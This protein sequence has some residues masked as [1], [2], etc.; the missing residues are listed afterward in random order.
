M[1]L[2]P[3]EAVSRLA[4]QRMDRMPAPRVYS[5]NRRDRSAFPPLV[6][7][8]KDQ[9]RRLRPMAAVLQMDPKQ[10]GLERQT[11][12]PGCLM[13][14]AVMERRM[15]RM[16]TVL[17]WNRSVQQTDLSD[18][19]GPRASAV[20]VV[21][22][23]MDRKQVA[24]RLLL[25]GRMDPPADSVCQILVVAV[26]ALQ[27]GQKK[28]AQPWSHFEVQSLA[29]VVLRTDQ[30]RPKTHL[31]IRTLAVVGRRMGP[32]AVLVVA[33][34]ASRMDQSRAVPP[35]Q[36]KERMGCFGS[37]AANSG[38]RMDQRPRL[39][40]AALEQ[41][42]DRNPVARLCSLAQMDQKARHLAVP[43]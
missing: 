2:P 1:D 37:S 11:D 6:V 22:R 38:W 26:V 12:P 3:Q 31:V 36:S 19:P 34:R 18:Y 25:K 28:A 13:I 27:T 16:Q 30:M 33:A 5:G 39:T 29:A 15:G 10:V 7:K 4:A 23:R 14:A 32:P 21:E 17:L 20:A 24:P 9:I 8:R 41:R 42:M 35:R 43:A 40:V